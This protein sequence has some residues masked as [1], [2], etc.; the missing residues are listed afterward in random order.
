MCNQIL[1]LLQRLDSWLVNAVLYPLLDIFC[2]CY[3]SL[4]S[5]YGF[6]AL[7]ISATKT[8]DLTTYIDGSC[9]V[10]YADRFQ[11]LIFTSI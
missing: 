5:T 1:D 4:A 6:N 7:S 3:I 2:L 8:D 11:M 10:D 9:K